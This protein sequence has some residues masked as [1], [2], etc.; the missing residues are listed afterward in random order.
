MTYQLR[1]RLRN[2]QQRPE[3]TVIYGGTVFEVLD[4]FSG[5]QNLAATET[6]EVSVAPGETRIVEIDTWCLN[7]NY[8]TPSNT[9]MRPT[10]LALA[11]Q[12]ESQGGLW[13]DLARRR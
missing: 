1:I 4:P 13:E 5:Y 3:R 11:S 10:S 8:R 7:Q 6:T 9:P 12:F 2:P